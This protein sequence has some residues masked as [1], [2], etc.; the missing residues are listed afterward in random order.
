M[1]DR[2]EA[3]AAPFWDRTRPRYLVTGLTRC[4]ACG[5]SFV[6]ISRDHFGCAGARNKGAA[7]CSN[8]LTIRRDVLENTI[9]DGLKHRLMD[10]DLFKVFV[11]EF[12]AELN[13]VRREQQAGATGVETE[14]RQIERR[15]ATIVGAIGDAAPRPRP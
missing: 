4:G 13:R 7:Y 11:T 1:L 14:L 8:L 9:I 3:E 6:K 2:R 12:T 15:I 5:S 10:P